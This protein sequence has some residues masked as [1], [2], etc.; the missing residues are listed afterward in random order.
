MFGNVVNKNKNL[1]VEDILVDVFESALDVVYLENPS[2]LRKV[3]S[4]REHCSFRDSRRPSGDDSGY[5]RADLDT[6]HDSVGLLQ[7]AADFVSV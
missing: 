2:K 1:Y 6:L 4:V 7:H 5:I 3:C